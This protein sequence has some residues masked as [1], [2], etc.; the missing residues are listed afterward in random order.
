MRDSGVLH[1]WEEGF[2][3]RWTQWIRYTSPGVKRM[4][5]LG[6]WLHVILSQGT[7]AR[8]AVQK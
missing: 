3:G 7:W 8:M 2:G 1:E 5:A 6:L 4:V